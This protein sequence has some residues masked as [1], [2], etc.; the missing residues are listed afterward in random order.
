MEPRGDH[1]DATETAILVQELREALAGSERHAEYLAETESGYR[2]LPPVVAVPDT[3]KRWRLPLL[4]AS[5]VL[6]IVIFI[7]GLLSA[8]PG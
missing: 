1:G 2:L 8:G 6:G 5:M 3:R 4:L 7:F